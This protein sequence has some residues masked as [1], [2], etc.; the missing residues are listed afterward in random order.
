M[1]DVNSLI[2][3]IELSSVLE[4]LMRNVNSLIKISSGVRVW[5]YSSSEILVNDVNSSA[6]NIKLS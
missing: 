6:L 3:N 2:R 5:N 4:A 1:K